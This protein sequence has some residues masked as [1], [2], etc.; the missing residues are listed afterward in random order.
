MEV[1]LIIPMVL[2]IQDHPRDKSGRGWQK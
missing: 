1:L 2:P